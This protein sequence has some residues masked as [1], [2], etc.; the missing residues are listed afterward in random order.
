M[1]AID[2]F[3]GLGG[4]THGMECAGIEVCLAANHWSWAVQTHA[5]NHRSTKH[6][7]QDLRQAD[8]S[9]WP[10]VELGWASPSC[11][12]HSQAAQPARKASGR[13][14]R[15]H[16]QLRASSWAV[17]DFAEV[18]R[19]PFLVIENVADVRRWALYPIWKQALQ[20]LGYQLTENLLTASKWGTPQ[21]RQRLFVIGH[22]G[23]PIALTDPDAPEPGFGPCVD[24][25]D[26]PWRSIASIPQGPQRRIARARARGLGDRFMVQ[27][28]TGHKGLALDEP[29]RTIT[30]GDQ[31]AVVDGDRYRT[32]T[33]AENLRAM[34][35]PDT[36]RFPQGS[37]RKDIIRAC[38]NAVAP[39]VAEGICRALQEVA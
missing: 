25:D 34:G 2:L 9:T 19:P 15:T 11:Q 23:A 1:K 10:D 22:L 33:I 12:G 16:D 36:Y 28:V 3:A 18:K 27:N 39:L 14:Q 21:R 7:C 13:V 17:V 29:I 26:G 20:T 4:A 8:F 32:L 31:W 5:L 24:W 37:W 30:S 38:G 35:L 6:L